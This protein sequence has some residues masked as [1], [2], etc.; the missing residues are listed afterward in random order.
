MLTIGQ[1]AT[2][3]GASPK[4]IRHFEALGLLPPV[5]RRGTYRCY[6]ASHLQAVA[7]IRQAQA[8]GFTLAE[9]KSFGKDDCTPDWPRFLH[10]IT[11][12]REMI[13]RE[14]KR[15]E[16]RDASLA[17][18]A[19]TLPAL[20]MGDARCE[21]LAE[22]LLTPTWHNETLPLVRSMPVSA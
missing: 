2:A 6:D 9:L 4:A 8:L 13:Q 7:L 1:A 20:L 3:T 10:A 18:L 21:A 14:L 19:Q 17:Q 22:R 12:K 16:A 11:A 5:H 15:L